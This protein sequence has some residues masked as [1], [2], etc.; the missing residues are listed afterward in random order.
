MNAC[1]NTSTGTS[2][3]SQASPSDVADSCLRTR[4]NVVR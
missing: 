3:G 4:K 1:T 2:K